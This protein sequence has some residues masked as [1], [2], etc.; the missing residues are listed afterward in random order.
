M[1]S[2]CHSKRLVLRILLC[3]VLVIPSVA[4][5]TNVVQET[6]VTQK[7]NFNNMLQNTDIARGG[8]VNGIQWELYVR[9]YKDEKLRSEFFLNIGIYSLHH[10]Q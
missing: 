4:F 8:G 1:F 7:I 5:S 2:F 3:F 10:V 9:Q 6:N